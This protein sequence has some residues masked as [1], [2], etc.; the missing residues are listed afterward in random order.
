MITVNVGGRRYRLPKSNVLKYPDTLLSSPASARYYFD[1]AKQEYFFD[2]DP[3]MFKYICQFYMTGKLHCPYEYEWECYHLYRDEMEFFGICLDNY[4]SRCCLDDHLDR[5]PSQ[6]DHQ[7]TPT[8]QQ[9]QPKHKQPSFSDDSLRGKIWKVLEDPLSSTT[10]KCFHIFIG[11]V[12]V[13]NVS[14]NAFETLPYSVDKT[15]GEYFPDA[16]FRINAVCVV[17]FTVEYLLGVVVAPSPCQHIRHIFNMIDLMAIIPFYVNIIVAN[18]YKASDQD[19]K[20]FAVL[21]VFRIFRVLKFARYSQKLIDL[22]HSI[23]KS[24]QELS[25]MLFSYSLTVVLF[26]SVLYYLEKDDV[27]TQFPSIPG[28]MWYTIVSTTTLG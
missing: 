10:A 1:E 20:S 5:V 22:F 24:S 27:K 9:Q 28:A 18:M 12:I 21:R 26:S 15:F 2:R 14:L 8:K 16:F 25:M 23:K 7:R 13:L 11:I 3:E 19:L 6:D 17:I 4:T